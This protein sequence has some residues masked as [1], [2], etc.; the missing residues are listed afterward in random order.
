VPLSA[1][2][3]LAHE[4][5]NRVSQA[6]YDKFIEVALSFLL[7]VL[8][9]RFV[10]RPFRSGPL[11]LSGSRLFALAGAV[12]AVVIVFSSLT[13]VAAGFPGRFSPKSLQIASYLDDPGHTASMREGT[14][15]ITSGNRF[16]EFK[17]DLCLHQ[18][19]GKRNYLLLGDSH[20]AA[21]W[22]ALSSSLPNDNIM[23]ANTSGCKP[24]VHS[25]GALDCKKM[26]TYIFQ[27]YLPSHPVEGL[28][29][30]DRWAPGDISGIT[31]TVEWARQHRIPVILFGPV[32][33]YDSPL[34]RLLAYSIT[35]NRPQLPAQ[36]RLSEDAILD[37]QLEN[38]A[39]NTWHVPYVSILKATCTN[40]ACTEYADAEHMVPF[41]FDGDHFTQA[42]SLIIVQ[43]LIASGQL[44][45]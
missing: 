28:L 19:D 37:S 10:E 26:M 4:L 34:P 35:W 40:G 45:L 25:S 17:D 3:A 20:S 6:R 12:M 27:S 21:L 32:Q 43:R 36:H 44:R 22:K 31:E 9:W 29:L 23:Q 41:M 7:A 14:C 11:K 1:I 39:A 24:F 38:L 13:V 33:E 42:G 5:G 8:S 18:I 2:A 30:E 15:F 16:T